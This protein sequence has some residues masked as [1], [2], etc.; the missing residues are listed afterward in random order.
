MP[1][2]SVSHNELLEWLN[3]QLAQQAKC[4]DCRFISITP[5]QAPGADGCNW[6][7]ATLRCSGVP[8]IDCAPIA[9]NVIAK[10]RTKFN[11]R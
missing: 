1:S 8:T 2:A 7:T 3:S 6:S 10:A 5:L 9:D 11:L 4:T